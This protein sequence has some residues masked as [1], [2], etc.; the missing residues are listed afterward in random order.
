M[1]IN[2]ILMSQYFSLF[3]ND[4]QK[5][6]K[7]RVDKRKPGRVQKYNIADILYPKCLLTSSFYDAW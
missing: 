1:L 7:K 3:A 4:M 5:L 2:Q 6:S